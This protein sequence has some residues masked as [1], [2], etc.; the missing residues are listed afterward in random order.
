[1]LPNPFS[2]GITAIL[3]AIHRHSDG[4]VTF[5][6]TGNG[7]F[8]NLFG[9]NAR[10][11]D[12]M[13]PQ[14]EEK[15]MKDSFFSLNAYW[16][17]ENEP[18]FLLAHRIR[19]QDRLRYLCTCYSDLDGYKLRLS[20][21]QL[22]RE[23]MLMTDR[24][25]VPNISGYA[26]SGRGLWVFWLLEDRHDSE[27]AQ[28]AF[29]EK[30]T[31]YDRIQ[32]E[33]HRRL[34]HLAADAKDACRLARIPGSKNSKN[35][36]RVRYEFYTDSCG[37]L[38]TYTLDALGHA[39]GLEST[40]VRRNSIGHRVPCPNRQRGWD[41][42][43][44]RRLRDFEGLRE[45]RE[46]FQDGCRNYA[47]M[48]YGWI[49]RC[50]RLSQAKIEAKVFALGQECRPPLSHSEC[51]GA[52]KTALNPEMKMVRDQTISDWLAIT[53]EE[54][55]LLEKFPAASR[56]PRPKQTL[57]AKVRMSATERRQLILGHIKKLKYVPST[58]KMAG[59]LAEEGCAVSHVSIAVDY[60]QLRA[61]LGPFLPP[62]Y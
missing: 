49:L 25:L 48:I 19:K 22:L 29:K 8:E 31:V 42:L 36:R 43:A 38:T 1:V 58:R 4:V 20:P 60:K 62:P 56:Y 30:I 23:I 24:G 57:T 2:K 5:H 10:H 27:K 41:A 37:S 47:A 15:L 6:T 51:R 18:H 35:N 54:A 14:V 45:I 9:L 53:P 55:E 39:L 46:V 28:A 16:C 3:R 17:G 12:T 13:L 32:D 40:G 21:K 33:L 52:L 61:S 7:K 59:M 50:N 11:L 34:G 44:S 26:H